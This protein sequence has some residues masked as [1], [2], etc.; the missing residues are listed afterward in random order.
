VFL[1]L[2]DKMFPHKCDTC[3]AKRLYAIGGKLSRIKYPTRTYTLEWKD[4][5]PDWTSQYAGRAW[6]PIHLS[7]KCLEWSL[8]LDPE[9]WDHWALVH[10]SCENRPCPSPCCDGEICR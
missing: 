4:G 8:D 5:E 9:H 2:L 1:K 7:T 3:L 10:E 6:L